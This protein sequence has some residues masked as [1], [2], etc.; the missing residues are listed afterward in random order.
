MKKGIL[1]L[2]ILFLAGA[3]FAYMQKNNP[4]GNTVTAEQNKDMVEK[5]V[6]DWADKTFEFY[7]GARF[8]KYEVATSTEYMKLEN[9]LT[10]MKEYKQ[11]MTDMFAKGELNKTKEEFDKMM[12]KNDRKID[13][14]QNLLNTTPAGSSGFEVDFSA[15]ILTNTGLTAYYK[16]HVVLNK[17]YVVT[18]HKVTSAIGK[19]NED[20]KILYKDKK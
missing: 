19:T 13:S 2:S 5:S 7:D 17:D 20:Q 18:S 3:G 8:D 14:L 15:N 16:H 6:L 11:E 10:G 12:A 9:K 4:G 1:L